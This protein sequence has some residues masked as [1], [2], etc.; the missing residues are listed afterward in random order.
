MVKKRYVAVRMPVEAYNQFCDR[1]RKMETVA[2]K[3]TK[4][5]IRIPLTKVFK[6]S[7]ENP[8]NIADDNLIKV[9]RK[10]RK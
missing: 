8:I 7:A 3:I 2:K 6:I 1:K 4:R 9:I 10:K 5:V